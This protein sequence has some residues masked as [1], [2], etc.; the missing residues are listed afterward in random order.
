MTNCHINVILHYNRIENVFWRKISVIPFN[1]LGWVFKN[2]VP[3]IYSDEIRQ[4]LC[5]FLIPLERSASVLDLGAGT[6]MMCEFANTCRDDLHFTA[7]DPA[8]G[9]LKFSADYIQKHKAYAEELPFEANS[10]EAILIGEALHHFNDVEKAF[11][12]IVRV[13]QKDGKLFI[14]DFDPSTF[15][16][17]M[18]CRVE[19]L[20]GE[21]GNFFSPT[22]LKK[23]L[24]EHGFSV[25]ISQYGWRY[26]ISAV[27]SSL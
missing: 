23:I 19:K 3:L 5:S 16:G 25:F 6:G 26:T 2:I 1:H 27:L 9:M 20:L 12:E 11:Q 24:E 22:A 7:A 4:S 21:P 18:L 14:Y 13:L 15:L 8:E 10:F 17:S